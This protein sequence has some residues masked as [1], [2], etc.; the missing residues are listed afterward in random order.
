MKTKTESPGKAKES[1]SNVFEDL[2]KD[3]YWAEK[4]LVKVL[5]KFAKAAYNE[6]L[7]TAFEKHAHETS[8]QVTRIEQCFEALSLKPE[9]K[10][11]EAMEGLV[12]EA[13]QAVESYSEGHVRDAALIAEAQKIEHY[14]ICS[15]GTLRTIAKVLGRVQCA[16]LLEQSKD[17]EA[18]ADEK[19]TNLAEKI[20]QQACE[21]PAVV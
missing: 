9:S 21:M 19:L 5:P 8:L 17:E 10:K 11:C 7:R 15:Y 3:I 6:D 14:E 4:Y 1:L 16:E 20:N 13:N 12:A 2:L 18:E